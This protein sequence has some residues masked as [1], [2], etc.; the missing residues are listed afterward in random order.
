MHIQKICGKALKL[1][2][3]INRISS[4][5]HLQTPLKKPLYCSLVR[6]ILEYGIILWDPSTASGNK[7]IERVQRKFLH[8]AS[9]K[10]NI[11]CPPHDYTPIQHLFSL[12]KTF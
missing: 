11:S 2:G 4:E 7:M 6:P 10:L 9:F 5:F 12:E 3:F 1:L 8:H